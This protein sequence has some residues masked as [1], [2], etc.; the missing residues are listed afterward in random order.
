MS[1]EWES[2]GWARL[3]SELPNNRTRI[4]GHKLKNRK[5]HLNMWKN[6]SVRLTKHWNRLPR[7]VVESPS[8]EIGKTHLDAYMCDL[9]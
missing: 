5:Y 2:S 3:F 7:E 8:Q 4:K 9:P 1:H 6:F